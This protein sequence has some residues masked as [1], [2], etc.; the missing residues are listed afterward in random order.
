MLVTVD[1]NLTN[2]KLE[3]PL[4]ST[5]PLVTPNDVTEPRLDTLLIPRPAKLS[6]TI[7]FGRDMSIPSAKDPYGNDAIRSRD[8]GKFIDTT[9]VTLRKAKDLISAKVSGRIT[10]SN[11]EL[12]KQP[13]FVLPSGIKLML[14]KQ[15]MC[16]NFEFEKHLLCVFG[17]RNSLRFGANNSIIPAY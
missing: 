2:S 14:P 3:Q 11:G 1:G 13:K 9:D 5:F 10:V 4:T 12:L 7:R 16:F 6:I 17:C 8:L 15:R